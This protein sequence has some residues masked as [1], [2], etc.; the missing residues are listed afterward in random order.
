[1]K[2]L[3]DDLRLINSK[4]KRLRKDKAADE[5]K[6][7]E[8]KKIKSEYPLILKNINRYGKERIELAGKFRS[9]KSLINKLEKEINSERNKALELRAFINAINKGEKEIKGKKIRFTVQK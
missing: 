8:I 5:L 7:R 2:K 9:T 3:N 1:M 6:L 4:L